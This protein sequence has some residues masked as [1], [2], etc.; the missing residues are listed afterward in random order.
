MGN[1]ILSY[2]NV[3]YKNGVTQKLGLI[4]H[5]DY[6]GIIKPTND[7]IYEFELLGDFLNVSKLKKSMHEMFGDMWFTDKSPIYSALET[8]VMILPQSQGGEQRCVLQKVK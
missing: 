1:K 3:T 8:G 2:Y 4:S 6:V 5:N 7:K